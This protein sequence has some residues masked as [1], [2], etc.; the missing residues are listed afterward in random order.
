MY[1]VRRGLSIIIS[2]R[3]APKQEDI[4][5]RREVVCTILLRPLH[6]RRTVESTTL[7]LEVPTIKLIVLFVLKVSTNRSPETPGVIP[8]TCLIGTLGYRLKLGISP[9]R[10]VSCLLRPYPSSPRWHL[11]LLPSPNLLQHL[12]TVVGRTVVSRTIFP[13]S[14]E[15]VKVIRQR[16]VEQITFLQP[17]SIFGR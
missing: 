17:T 9:L 15:L 16:L 11:C 14:F 3:L 1:N 8:R 10:V 5:L 6:L 7:S 13:F 4:L 2:W 12:R